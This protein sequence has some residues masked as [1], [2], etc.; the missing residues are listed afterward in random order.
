LASDRH[1]D[2][3]YQQRHLGLPPVSAIGNEKRR[4]LPEKSPGFST[5]I[6]TCHFLA[7]DKRLRTFIEYQH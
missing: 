3:A 2:H 1:L 6:E 7:P 5:G 4:V